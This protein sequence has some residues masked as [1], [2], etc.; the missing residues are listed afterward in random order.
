MTIRPQFV[1]VAVLSWCANTSSARQV[2]SPGGWHAT[3]SAAGVQAAGLASNAA[4]VLRDQEAVHPSIPARGFTAT[5]SATLTPPIAGTFVFGVD[6]AGGEAEVHVES[7]SGAELAKCVTQGRAR[8]TT[9]ALQLGT[10]P[11]RVRVVYTRGQGELARLRAL[12]SRSGVDGFELEPIPSWAV[13][14]PEGKMQDVG[15]DMM[16]VLGRVL[17]QQKGCTNCHEPSPML[18]TVVGRR[19]GPTLDTLAQRAEPAWAAHWLETY[20]RGEGKGDMPSVFV[21]DEATRLAAAEDIAHYIASLSSTPAA[22]PTPADEQ[23]DAQLEQGRRLYHT[24]GC[25]V[26]HGPLESPFAVFHDPQFADEVPEVRVP[27]AYG[28]IAGKWRRDGLERLLRDPTHIY[29]DGRMPTLNLTESEAAAIAAYLHTTMERPL[30]ALVPAAERVARGKAA[31]QSAGCASCHTIEG[32]PSTRAP[33]KNLAELDP[34]RGCLDGAD[35]ATP[36]YAFGPGER[37]ALI[38]G[39][40][41]VKAAFGKTS[42]LDELRRGRMY[43]SCSACHAKDG[44]GGVNAALKPYFQSA[45]D[46]VDLGDEGRIPPDLTSVGF[47]LRTEWMEE[48][49]GGTERARPFMAVRMPTFTQANVRLAECFSASEGV[50]RESEG[51]PPAPTDDAAQ[52]GRTLAGAQGLNCVNCHNFK[53]LPAAGTPGPRLDQ[54]HERL[55]Y[56][57]WT[58]YFPT[59]SRFKPGTRMPA[60]N[61]NGQTAVLDLYGG[62]WHRQADAL[63]SYMAQR[64]L[65]LPPSGVEPAGTLTL[66][67][68]REPIVFRAFLES[69]GT[70]AILV[71]TPVGLH[72]AFDSRACRLVEAWRGAFVDAAGAWSGRGGMNVEGRGPIVWKAPTGPPLT[73]RLVPRL[74][75]Q[76]F[77]TTWTFEG[78]RLDAKRH[79]TFLY[80]SNGTKVSERFEGALNPSLK[81]VRRFEVVTGSNTQVVLNAGKGKVAVSDVIGTATQETRADGDTWVTITAPPTAGGTTTIR[82]TLE[83]S[84]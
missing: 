71:G 47:K 8:A 32:A 81:I 43:N 6:A 74:G 73:V 68:S 28:A 40:A 58:A 56:E 62:D 23:N 51:S 10:E 18:A 50:L 4:F 20:A 14:L 37:D 63:W 54:F 22:A 29:P 21:G 36:R 79:P 33:A 45:D 53:D 42:P 26:C 3:Y 61:L 17:L 75:D 15:G 69:A 48:M 11:V 49:I 35:T 31:F 44:V 7:T 66:D 83:V 72:F 65:M 77:T 27:R 55:R 2:P 25:I 57:W 38:A 5:Y 16:H 78:Y 13:R 76:A 59:P 84:P 70:K 39:L 24:V 67:P 9:G 1:L 60:F 52:N 64:D 46:R 80:E 12:W 30:D 82:F 41:A 34:A 19:P